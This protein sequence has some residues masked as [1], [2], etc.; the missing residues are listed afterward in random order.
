MPSP[1][2]L[3]FYGGAGEIGGN[4]ILLQTPRSKIYLDF[5]QSFDFGSSESFLE[6]DENKD[7]RR[8][9]DNW[10]KHFGI[11][12]HKAHCSGHAGKSDLKYAV[13]KINPEILIPIHTQNPEEFKKIHD[14]VIIPKRGET[15]R[16]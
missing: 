13:R 3:T 7:Q 12:L 5:G 10:L 15:I 9:L 2:S 11:T 16:L 4:K 8:V 1:L 6:G 14:N